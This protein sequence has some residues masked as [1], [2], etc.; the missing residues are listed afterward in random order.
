MTAS[1]QAEQGQ[2][3]YAFQSGRAH[4]TAA[5]HKELQ[6]H[7]ECEEQEK[8]SSPGP[9]S[10]PWNRHMRSIIQTEQGVAVQLRI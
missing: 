6:E 3:Q 1:T 8:Q 4:Q 9:S 10:H 7:K 5:L 2:Q